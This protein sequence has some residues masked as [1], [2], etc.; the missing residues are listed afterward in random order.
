[1]LCCY[2]ATPCNESLL[3]QVQQ[4]QREKQ[5]LQREKYRLHAE[6]QTARA[7]ISILSGQLDSVTAAGAQLT[8]AITQQGDSTPLDAIQVAARCCNTSTQPHDCKTSQLSASPGQVLQQ[9]TPHSVHQ[10]QQDQVEAGTI[11]G[12]ISAAKQTDSNMQV[13]HA[14][15]LA[16]TAT[17]RNS[18]SSA[19]SQ[20]PSVLGEKLQQHPGWSSSSSSGC[21][22]LRSKQGTCS[23]RS[24]SSSCQAL[25]NCKPS[26]ISVQE[27]AVPQASSI[28]TAAVAGA[29]CPPTRVPAGMS[30]PTGAATG[31]LASAMHRAEYMPPTTVLAG[32]HKSSRGPGQHPDSCALSQQHSES[33]PRAQ[34]QQEMEGMRLDMLRGMQ[35]V[36][37]AGDSAPAPDQED[38]LGPSC[39]S[40]STTEPAS[41]DPSCCPP[42]EGD[43]RLPL[44]LITRP[45][46]QSASQSSSEVSLEGRPNWRLPLVICALP[47]LPPRHGEVSSAAAPVDFSPLH[48]HRPKFHYSR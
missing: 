15:S 25:P 6:L 47:V 18:S 9:H 36:S 44:D 11:T 17:N 35:E 24:S 14:G 10:Q 2:T 20:H 3:Q 5:Q 37:D 39:F 31:P 48:Q 4:L 26:Y 29:N 22:V 34:R 45:K 7:E 40:D 21:T 41:S 32:Q 43:W 23:V 13:L 16:S 30:A 42:S 33:A 8:A 1:M 38:R 12:S 28:K 46:R 19:A 27:P